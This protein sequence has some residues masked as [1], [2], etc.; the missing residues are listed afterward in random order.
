[1]R[2]LLGQ[3]VLKC[4]QKCT[5][6]LSELQIELEQNKNLI[7]AYCEVQ[8]A[9]KLPLKQYTFKQ[10]G[11]SSKYNLQMFFLSYFAFVYAKKFLACEKL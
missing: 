10:R 7:F 9:Q 11:L 1:M 2:C 5:Q 4:W 8:D 6:A 3:I